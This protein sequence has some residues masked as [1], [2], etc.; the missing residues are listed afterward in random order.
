MEL[1]V[2]NEPPPAGEFRTLSW[3]VTEPAQT[4]CDYRILRLRVIKNIRIGARLE[5]TGNKTHV[6][7]EEC[8]TP[9]GYLSIQVLEQ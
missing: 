2:F 5:Q 1:R 7:F 6:A 8:H 3:A 4:R 9:P